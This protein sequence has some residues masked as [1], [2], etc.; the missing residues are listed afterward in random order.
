MGGTVCRKS[1]VSNR[2]S[3][4]QR[5]ACIDI[6]FKNRQDHVDDCYEVCDLFIS[7]AMTP[8][9]QPGVLRI[10]LDCDSD[11]HFEEAYATE[12]SLEMKDFSR[13]S[14]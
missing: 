2:L 9:S 7:F 3:V 1:L 12:K 13:R 5:A 14:K 6:F 11:C 4:L 10:I 8:L